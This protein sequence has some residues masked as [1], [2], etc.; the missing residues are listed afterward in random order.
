MNSRVLQIGLDYTYLNLHIRTFITTPDKS[1]QVAKSSTNVYQS[2][3]TLDNDPTWNRV[4]DQSSR[5]SGWWSIQAKSPI[6]SR[7]KLVQPS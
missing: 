1:T 3:V 7:M 2:H 6:L 4:A 5:L